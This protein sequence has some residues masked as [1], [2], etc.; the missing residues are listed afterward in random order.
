MRLILAA[1]LAGLAAL[2]L[3]IAPASAD[4]RTDMK[5]LKVGFIAGDN[6]ALQSL[7]LEKFRAALEAGLGM[8][9]QL[10]PARTYQALIEAE[11]SG[12]IQYAI[13]SSLAFIALDEK[14]QCGEP[15]VQPL[16]DGGAR[17]F[18]AL[19]VSETKDGILTLA[20]ARGARLAVGKKD[21]LSARLLPLSALAAAG[22]EPD[23]YFA[24]VAETDD[25]LAALRMLAAGQADLAVAWSTAEDPLNG[26]PESGPISALASEGA[27]SS[28]DL[29]IVWRSDIVPFGPHVVR[30]DMPGEA[31]AMLKATLLA[32]QT[33]DPDAYDAAEPQFTGGFAEADP[34]HYSRFAL[35]LA[36]IAKP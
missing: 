11:S 29:H 21:S 30:K 16:G 1:L 25:S 2:A 15:L 19:L 10:F 24:S 9:V 12:R 6:P 32:M 20:D 34:Q 26:A 36:D 14:C 13:L 27:L 4:W 7:Q 18:R 17:G 23:S 3:Q 28:R 22:V 8:P 33:S 5:V 35:L 31:K